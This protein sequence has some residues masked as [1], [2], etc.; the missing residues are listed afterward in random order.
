M[1]AT[2]ETRRIRSTDRVAQPC[3]SVNSAERRS[4]RS[5]SILAFGEQVQATKRRLLQFLI[6]AKEQG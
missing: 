6:D 5:S 4:T 1:R 2:A 3:G